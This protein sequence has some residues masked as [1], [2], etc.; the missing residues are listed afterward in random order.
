[1]SNLFVVNHIGLGDHII[2]N[3][4]YR[5]H[6]QRNEDVEIPCYT[7]NLPSVKQMLGDVKNARIVEIRNDSEML[8]LAEIREKSGWKVLRLGMFGKNFDFDRWIQ[9][10]YQQA[11]MMAEDRYKYF[12]VPRVKSQE[13]QDV[14]GTP[15]VF[16]HEDPSRG[17]RIDCKKVPQIR[18]IQPSRIGS[19]FKWMSIIE[20]AKEIHCIDSCFMCLCDLMNVKC[21][22]VLH[23]YARNV[24]LALIRRD[25]EVID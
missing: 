24:P 5:Y 21:K 4:I 18:K 19:V 9:C 13:I 20:G 12:V 16:M 7:H 6:A 14:E 15:Y 25:W 10:F 17:L 11:G 8:R 23:R 3:G 22:K 2:C 1:M